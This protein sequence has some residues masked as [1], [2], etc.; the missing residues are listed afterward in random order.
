MAQS[1]LASR[2]AGIEG[3]DETL[4]QVP[5]NIHSN[6]DTVSVSQVSQSQYSQ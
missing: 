3:A 1:D 5:S 2:H 6:Y 4:S